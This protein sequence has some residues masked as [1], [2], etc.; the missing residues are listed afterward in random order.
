MRKNAPLSTNTYKSDFGQ[1]ETVERK[2]QNDKNNR[3]PAGPC[4]YVNY[5]YVK[6]FSVGDD[7][8]PAYFRL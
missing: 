7:F 2:L 5:L 3:L 1:K 8:A 4:T 6:E